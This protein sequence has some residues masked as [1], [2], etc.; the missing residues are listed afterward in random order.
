[1]ITNPAPPAETPGRRGAIKLTENEGLIPGQAFHQ[2][3]LMSENALSRNR[4]ETKLPAQARA[5]TELH[6]ARN[7]WRGATRPRESEEGG[8][9]MTRANNFPQTVISARHHDALILPQGSLKVERKWGN[10]FYATI[11]RAVLRRRFRGDMGETNRTGGFDSHVAHHS[12]SN[13]LDMRERADQRRKGRSGAQQPP[14]RHD[15]PAHV[16][17]NERNRSRVWG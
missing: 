15:P 7:G 1:M 4:R 3:L 10:S 5:Q 2:H 9:S 13:G 8:V 6:I 14:M 12:G 16:E 11:R 17:E